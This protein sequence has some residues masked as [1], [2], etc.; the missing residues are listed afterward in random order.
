MWTPSAHV[1]GLANM[2][3][4][5]ATAAQ[6]QHAPLT[7]LEPVRDLHP[8][9]SQ[10]VPHSSLSNDQRPLQQTLRRNVIHLYPWRVRKALS[11]G[12]RAG[13]RLIWEQFDTG[14]PTLPKPLG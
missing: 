8:S 10:P 6:A 12:G 4:L 3:F 11:E 7:D 9:C 14:R 2:V 1:F 13:L 5:D